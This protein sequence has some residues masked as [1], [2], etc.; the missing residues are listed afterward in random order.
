M[1]C[2][3]IMT[4]T[5]NR[6]QIKAPHNWN[7][8]LFFQL[9]KKKLVHGNSMPEISKNNSKKYHKYRH[10]KLSTKCWF[11]L[12]WERRM[13]ARNSSQLVPQL[14]IWQWFPFHCVYLDEQKKIVWNCF[15]LCFF[16]FFFTL[17][18]NLVCSVISWGIVDRKT[19]LLFQY[20]K[21]ER[22]KGNS[23]NDIMRD[24]SG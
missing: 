10:K 24:E 19:T 22:R 18:C 23:A 20:D 14:L 16:C 2:C 6:R 15:F 8:H 4:K 11:S 5:A 17:K 3:K 1:K 13:I 9:P 7:E 12:E 21:I